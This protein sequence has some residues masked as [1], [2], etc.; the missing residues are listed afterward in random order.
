MHGTT[1]GSHLRMVTLVS[2]IQL[3]SAEHAFAFA[4]NPNRHPVQNIGIESAGKIK[5]LGMRTNKLYQRGLRLGRRQIR[6][7]SRRDRILRFTEGVRRA[8]NYEEDVPDHV[9]ESPILPD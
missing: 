6:I 1:P 8:H 9:Q 5:G 7:R 3:E 2:K 4:V